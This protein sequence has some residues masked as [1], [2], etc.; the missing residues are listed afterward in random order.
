MCLPNRFHF[1]LGYA[2]EGHYRLKPSGS[3]VVLSD[4][5][6]ARLDTLS[7][8]GELPVLSDG[9]P[10]NVLEGTDRALY[11]VSRSQG[12]I[13]VNLLQGSEWRTSKAVSEVL[14]DFQTTKLDVATGEVAFRGKS[15]GSNRLTIIR[16][17][18]SGSQTEDFQLP[19]T[20]DS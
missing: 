7:L 5:G 1:G 19:K 11:A 16:P 18:A 14:S 10:V 8:G 9:E 6:R 17:N 12:K 13:E 2:L 20:W 4:L 15:P 3:N